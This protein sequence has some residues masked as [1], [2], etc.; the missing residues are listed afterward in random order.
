MTKVFQFL[1]STEQSVIEDN[2]QKLKLFCGL[3]PIFFATPLIFHTD[4]SRFLKWWWFF[5]SFSL[6]PPECFWNTFF[7]KSK[8]FLII[9][10][11]SPS[12]CA[13]SYDFLCYLLD[14]FFS[15]FSRMKNSLSH[16]CLSRTK[17][18]NSFFEVL[19][20]SDCTILISSIRISIS[21]FQYYLTVHWS[22]PAIC[23]IVHATICTFTFV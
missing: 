1:L 21:S 16:R 5:L 10:R 17:N 22:I 8:Q 2:I 11:N 9:L 15:I 12:P 14:I 23:Q 4:I 19:R 13:N 6:W 3:L 7:Q 18:N 20:S